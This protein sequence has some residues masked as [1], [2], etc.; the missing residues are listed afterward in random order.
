MGMLTDYPFF[1]ICQYKSEHKEINND[2]IINNTSKPNPNGSNFDNHIMETSLENIKKEIKLIKEKNILDSIKK[3]CAIQNNIKK[4][5][6][7]N[8]FKNI[9]KDSNKNLGVINKIDSNM[10]KIFE[11][12]QNNSLCCVNFI[13]KK[14]KNVEENFFETNSEI[15]NYIAVLY[16][17]ILYVYYELTRGTYYIYKLDLND[18]FKIA[19]ENPLKIIKQPPLGYFNLPS[20]E[21]KYLDILFT[22]LIADVPAAY[23][24]ILFNL[25]KYKD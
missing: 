6:K 1:Q 23:K 22:E 17:R 8:C 4:S 19:V 24:K 13:N 5:V 10:L 16:Y 15:L 7:Y 21:K 2:K 14:L 11:E 25:F 12:F 3:L 18:F 20:I 9:K